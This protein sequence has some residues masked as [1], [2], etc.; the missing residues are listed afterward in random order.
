[1]FQLPFLNN[2][3]QVSSGYSHTLFLT[4]SGQVYATGKNQVKFESKF[5][6]WTA[7]P[8]R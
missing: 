5:L 4:N 3:I 6:V 7:W 1:M 8:G 2:I